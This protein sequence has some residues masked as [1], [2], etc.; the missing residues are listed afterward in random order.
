MRNE[1]INT[2]TI[3]SDLHEDMDA[4]WRAANH[5]SICR[6]IVFRS[7]SFAVEELSQAGAHHTTP[8]CLLGHD[9]ELDS[10]SRRV[11]ISQSHAFGTALDNP[12]LIVRRDQDGEP[13]V[14]MARYADGSH[15]NQGPP[16]GCGEIIF[17]S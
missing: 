7:E 14:V 1:P 3:S 9:A 16:A 11:G 13:D 10:R 12:G 4:Q 15:R 2:R 8:A 6:S 5:L 17:P